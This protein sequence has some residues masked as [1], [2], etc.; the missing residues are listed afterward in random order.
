PHAVDPPCH[1]EDNVR[2]DEACAGNHRVQGDENEEDQST[3][4]GDGPSREAGA[5]RGAAP[6]APDKSGKLEHEP[7]DGPRP[8]VQHEESSEMS[9]GWGGWVL[10]C[11]RV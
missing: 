10:S 2:V 6:V 9:S 11:L 5:K 3:R 1:R 7:C 4:A 8:Q